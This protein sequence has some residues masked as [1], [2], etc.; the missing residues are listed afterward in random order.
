MF[1]WEVVILEHPGSSGRSVKTFS[2]GK[3]FVESLN[4][5]IIA[6]MF[7]RLSTFALAIALE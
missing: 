5:H 4:M 1:S 7:S 2:I 3:L 6:M